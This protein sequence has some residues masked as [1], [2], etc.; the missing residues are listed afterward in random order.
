MS[1]ILIYYTYI[2]FIV[3]CKL[4]NILAIKHSVGVTKCILDL[5]DYYNIKPIRHPVK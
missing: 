4:R 3:V 2:A 5:G 1:F